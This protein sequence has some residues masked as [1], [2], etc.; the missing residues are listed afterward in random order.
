MK[1][2]L[3]KS[4]LRRYL[5]SFVSI[6]MISCAV[7]GMIMYM[8][9]VREMRAA[10]QEEQYKRLV[11]AAEDMDSQMEQLQLIAHRLQGTVYYA[12]T[13]FKR[14]P[15]YEVELLE[16]LKRFT[17]YSSLPEHFFVRYKEEDAVYSANG[18]SFM[19]VYAPRILG[20]DDAEALAEYLD[21]CKSPGAYP[22]HDGVLA[23]FPFSFNASKAYADSGT[24]CFYLTEETLME[25]VW[26]IFGQRA[27]NMEIIWKDA[28][29][30]QSGE[31]D[32]PVAAQSKH[33]AITLD[34]KEIGFHVGEEFVHMS[35][36]V[37]CVFAV[38]LCVLAVV[39]AVRSYRPIG[40]IARRHNLHGADGNELEHLDRA[41]SDTKSQLKISQKQLDEKLQQLRDMRDDLQRYFTLCLVQGTADTA[42]IDSMR[43]AGMRFP[44]AT[45]AAYILKSSV[46]QE[47]IYRTVEDMSDDNLVFYA[48][49][50]G[51]E[52]HYAVLVNG[53]NCAAAGDMLSE[54]VDAEVFGGK[55][56]EALGE[57][58]SLLFDALTK[59]SP[60]CIRPSDIARCREDERLRKFRKALE[61]GDEVTALE[62]MRGYFAT[63]AQDDQMLQELIHNNV[64]AM[65]L[66]ASYEVNMNVPRTFLR[67]GPETWP[68]LEGWVSAL[69][70][71]R[72]SVPE[73]EEHQI[74]RYLREHAL[75]YDLMLEGVAEH[76]RRSSRQIT[77]I[78]QAET[79]C[80]YKEFILRLRMEHAKQMLKSGKSV[81][82]TCEKVCYASRSHFI[83][84]FTNYA[85]MT[86]SRYRDS[87]LEEG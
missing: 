21:H 44:G 84:T 35:L 45:F 66:S 74:I 57:I 8:V 82:E 51:G 70:A 68:L 39:A 85:G 13:Y 18:K 15:Y 48:V 36:L 2:F 59:A 20:Y 9:S 27:E 16:D 81:A 23:V 43:E 78:I 3:G 60:S 47:S 41:L 65:L 75:D 12:P 50:F 62:S 6:A 34:Q 49:P 54:A 46:P 24:M 25:R 26:L 83:K 17:N 10:A 77:R 56:T 29:L 19:H 4:V 79:G 71:N 67:G 61:N 28:L 76:F 42:T 55:Q 73:H 58:P 72:D 32:D 30:V 11:L 22:L 69:C 33:T 87:D 52:K 31:M 7:I 63:Y 1:R 40:N 5:F 64:T 80:S 53:D 86:P 37:I 38:L 14:N